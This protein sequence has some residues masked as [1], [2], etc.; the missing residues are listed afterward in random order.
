MPS[1]HPS[2]DDI[3]KALMSPPP[4]SFRLL[5]AE[6]DLNFRTLDLAV[7][8]PT[9][10][11]I[12]TAAGLDARGDYSLFAI[13][14][15]GDFEDVRLDEACDLNDCGAHR[16][17]AFLTDRD[18][19]LTVKGSQVAW[20][21]PAISAA[22][23]YKLAKA[24]DKQAVFLVCHDGHRRLIEQGELVDLTPPGIEHFVTDAL[25]FE[26]IVNARPRTVTGRE[27]TF[28]EIVSLAFPGAHAANVIFSMTYRHAASAPHAGEL[29]AGGTVEVKQ[30]TIFNVTRT[31]QS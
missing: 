31:V 3:C 20:G 1:E 19:K 16:V 8:R 25:T 30:G 23:L 21:K 11:Q 10:H 13:L 28:A 6:G 12:L 29:A 22:I 27:V 14:P 17:I 5:Y 2:N 7:S 15:N 18:F 9:G 24:N 26:I 4:H